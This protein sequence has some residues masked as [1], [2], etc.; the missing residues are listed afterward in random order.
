MS[1]VFLPVWSNDARLRHAVLKTTTGGYP[2]VTLGYCGDGLP[3]ERVA[4]DA[5]TAFTTSFLTNITLNYAKI[6]SFECGGSMRHDVLLMLD[7]ESD[8]MIEGMRDTLRALHPANTY[9][10]VD[11][12]VTHAIFCDKSSAETAM[13]LVSTYLPMTVQITGVT[14]D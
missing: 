11:A 12:H 3:N 10:F 2:H 9:S 7:E 14:I 8:A 5:L 4:L 6:N 1:G 13:A